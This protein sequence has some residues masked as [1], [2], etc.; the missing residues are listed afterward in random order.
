[1]PPQ[2]RGG[3]GL[4]PGHKADVR[5]DYAVEL[6]EQNAGNRRHCRA[7]HKRQRNHPV[8]VDA[9]QVAI[10]RSSAQARQARPMREER[11]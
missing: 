5:V 2:H 4:H 7:D 11:I 1:M 9:E 6:T 8:G 10:F 3:E